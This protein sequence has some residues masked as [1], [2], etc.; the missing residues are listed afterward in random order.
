MG[1][2]EEYDTLPCVLAVEA[3]TLMT[4]QGSSHPATAKDLSAQG[5]ARS[6]PHRACRNAAEVS[7]HGAAALAS[8][9]APKRA[10]ACQSAAPLRYTS[11]E[12]GIT[13]PAAR[14]R[15]SR[16]TASRTHP[17]APS[18]C[19]GCQEKN[20]LRAAKRVNHGW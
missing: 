3:P 16:R 5:R 14:T 13:I 2:A 20:P 9:R 17:R 6:Q 19:I 4:A 8:R 10:P 1:T 18:Q 12:N 15:V 11:T 7:T